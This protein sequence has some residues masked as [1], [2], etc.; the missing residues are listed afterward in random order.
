LLTRMEMQRPVVGQGSN[1]H[2][3]GVRPNEKPP[4]LVA[5]RPHAKSELT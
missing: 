2:I 5:V 1:F 3:I 4:D